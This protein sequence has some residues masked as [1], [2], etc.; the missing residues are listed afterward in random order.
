[1][2]SCLSGTCCIR[3]RS[4]CLLLCANS[5]CILGRTPRYC[6]NR[7]QAQISD[8]FW[9]F[10]ELGLGPTALSIAEDRPML[11]KSS[12][13]PRQTPSPSLQRNTSDLAAKLHKSPSDLATRVLR[14]QEV[15]AVKVSPAGISEALTIVTPLDAAERQLCGS[16]GSQLEPSKVLH[17]CSSSCHQ[18]QTQL[19][20][21]NCASRSCYMHCHA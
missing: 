19:N 5:L 12:P 17:N 13:Q 7:N 2:S 20:R 11:F 18:H 16:Q 4:S 1:M 9:V 3:R 15:Q 21:V 6:H 8:T 14:M 10:A